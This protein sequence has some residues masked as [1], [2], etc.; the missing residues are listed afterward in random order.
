MRG[1]PH[2]P[3]FV[4]PACSWRIGPVVVSSSQSRRARAEVRTTNRPDACLRKSRANKEQ[5][6][7][8]LQDLVSVTEKTK[9]IPGLSGVHAGSVGFLGAD[10]ARGL[11]H[12]RGNACVQ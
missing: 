12:R 2:G 1:G 3:P 9:R 6:T 8:K 7:A 5:K 10:I 4:A 11:E